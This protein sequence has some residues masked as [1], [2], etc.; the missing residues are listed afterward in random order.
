MNKQIIVHDLGLVDYQDA[1][2]Y[3][4]QLFNQIIDIKLKNRKN[5]TKIE[6]DNHL[7]FVEHPNVYTLGKSGDINNLLLNKN[8]LD[9]KKI[10]FFNTN[11]GGDITCH[12]PGQIVCYPILDLD[13]FFTDIHKYL[14]FLEETI[15]RTLNDFG[16]VSERSQNETGVWID[17][18]LV[19]SR[20]ICAMGVKASRWVTMHGLALNVNNDLSYFEN[21]IPCGISNKS[22]TSIQ[23][24]T[25]RNISLNQVTKIITQH[26]IEIFS[27]KLV[28]G[29]N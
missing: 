4:L 7:I 13:N 29:V 2:D 28:E 1:L 17:S 24:E 23:K 21:I 8:E 15:I 25:G 16:I 12:G 19:F 14:R 3:Q 9:D 22:V 5:N 11:R 10:Q 6:T 20:K 26:F 27:A 18:D